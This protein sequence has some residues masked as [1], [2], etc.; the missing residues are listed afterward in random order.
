MNEDLCCT[1]LVHLTMKIDLAHSLVLSLSSL[2][3]GA[4]LKGGHTFMTIGPMYLT[5]LS[6]STKIK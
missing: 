2:D 1:L 4:K 6:C 3:L 5:P